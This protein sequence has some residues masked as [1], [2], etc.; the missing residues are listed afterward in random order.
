MSPGSRYIII[1]DLEGVL[2]IYSPDMENSGEDFGTFE[3][4]RNC[5]ADR[6]G[7]YIDSRGQVCLTIPAPVGFKRNIHVCSSD[8]VATVSVSSTSIGVQTDD[9]TIIPVEER[10]PSCVS[11]VERSLLPVWG[12]VNPCRSPCCL[13]VTPEIAA[14]DLVEVWAHLEG[15]GEDGNPPLPPPAEPPP[16][17][18][19]TKDEDKIEEIKSS[20]WLAKQK[21]HCI[22]HHVFNPHLSWLSGQDQESK[23]F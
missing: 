11:A 5:F 9:C 22:D 23:A 13:P 18:Q 3:F 1:F 21:R 15:E 6:R 20:R 17:V 16:V 2:P 8:T 19:E 14:P 10:M 12:K 7:I 4:W